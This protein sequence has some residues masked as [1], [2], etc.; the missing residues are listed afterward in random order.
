MEYDAEMECPDCDSTSMVTVQSLNEIVRWVC[1]V[2]G[3][4]HR[5][6]RIIGDA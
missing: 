3:N 2:C 6:E 1:P 5:E 4:E